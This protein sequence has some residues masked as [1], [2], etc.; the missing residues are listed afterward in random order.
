MKD[1]IF[2]IGGTDINTNNNTRNQIIN[3]SIILLKIN[4]DDVEQ[5]MQTVVEM[6]DN[7]PRFA[8]L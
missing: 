2:F 6:Y 5:Y 1:D 7:N 3:R 8:E 4:E